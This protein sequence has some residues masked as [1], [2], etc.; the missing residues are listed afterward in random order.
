MVEIE[1]TDEGGLHTRVMH[2]PSGQ[3]IT[4]DAPKDNHGKGEAFSPTDLVAAALGSC[5]LT[6]MSLVA[7]RHNVDLTGTRARVIKEMT[8]AGPRRIQS[9]EATVIFVT[10]FDK[11]QR[12]LLERAALACPVHH[13]LHPDV[14]A[15]VR[16]VY[17]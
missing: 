16:F 3:A 14:S 13:S 1:A 5:L 11:A 15:P 7:R 4:T 12:A 8:T 6:T 2:G 9:L 17:P 10:R